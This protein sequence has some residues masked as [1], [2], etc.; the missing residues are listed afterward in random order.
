MNRRCLIQIFKLISTLL[1]FPFIAS[2]ATESEVIN[3]ILEPYNLECS[4]EIGNVGRG[5]V[6]SEI[7]PVTV[8]DESIYQVD[9]TASG[10]KATVLFADFTCPGHG[11]FWCGSSGCRVYIIVDG[12]LHYSDHG[13]KP[14][15]VTEGEAVFVLLPKSGGNCGKRNGSP[16]YRVAIWDVE[17]G[18]FNVAGMK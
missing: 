17:D 13:F 8:S 12:V 6:I 5:E 16:C 15:S 4:A 7:V 9:I 14:F 18:E 11:S 3:R 10:K 2:A 1:L